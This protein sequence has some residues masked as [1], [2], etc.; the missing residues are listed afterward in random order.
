MN[1]AFQALVSEAVG[2]PH[3]GITSVY[4]IDSK[5]TKSYVQT[6]TT[7][8]PFTTIAASIAAAVTAGH[9]DSNPAWHNIISPISE[10]V[11]ITHGGEF[12]S[13]NGS[14][15]HSPLNVTGGFTFNGADTTLTANHFSLERLG[16]SGTSTDN[17]IA[18]TG[19]QPQRLFL[20]DVWLTANGAGATGLFADNIGTGSTIEIDGLKVS[21]TATTGDNYCIDIGSGVHCY[22]DDL[23]TSG[24]NV[25]VARVRKG[26]VVT[27][28]GSE[29][30]ASGDEAIH[31]WGG[32]SLTGGALTVSLSTITNTK[33]NSSGI[34]LDPGSVTVLGQTFFNIPMGVGSLTFGA[35]SG[36]GITV[37]GVGTAFAATDVGRM[38]TLDSGKHAIITAFASATSITV[39]LLT[40]ISTTTF[41]TG[42]WSIGFAIEGSTAGIGSLTFSSLTAGTGITV[43]G[44]GTTFT[45]DMVGGWFTL[46]SGKKAVITAFASATSMTVTIPVTLS[47]TTYAT[48][49]WSID[50]AVCYYQPGGISFYPC[51]NS[52]INPYV[53]MTALTVKA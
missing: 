21:H 10:T 38:F 18:F 20:K 29:C 11:T 2:S 44:V 47:S 36:S 23:E 16:V 27:I 8:T 33:A 35:T 19:I 51:S 12:V 25:Q 46:D 15:T 6:G 34:K 39:T 4:S 7:T 22:L 13:G 24:S 14:G 48:L 45:A 26:A 50:G 9:N 42:T 5:R 31:V 30:D 41:A 1:P 3:G 32:A 40:T 49:T 52:N 28:T 17:A 37:T 43:T 53:T